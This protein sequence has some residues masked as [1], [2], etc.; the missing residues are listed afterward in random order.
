MLRFGRS[1]LFVFL[2]LSW[3]KEVNSGFISSCVYKTNHTDIAKVLGE[4]QD[5]PEDCIYYYLVDREQKRTGDGY[6]LLLQPPPTEDRINVTVD[7]VLIR[8]VDLSWHD[9]RLSWDES[10]FSDIQIFNLHDAHH[11]WTPQ[12]GDETA[13]TMQSG[14]MSKINDVEISSS[15][16][17]SARVTFRYPTFCTINYYRYPE[18]TNDCCLFLSNSEDNHDIKYNIHTRAK[19][20]VEK[21]VAVSKVEQEPG[22]TVVTTVDSSV[23]TVEDRTIDVAKIAGVRSEFLRLCVHAVKRMSTLRMALRV[24]VTIA[25]M[26]ML[27]APLF[28]DL[29]TQ[30]Y[31]KLVTL[32][33]Q[34]MCFLFLCSIAP[35]NGFGG[36]KPKIYTFYE[37]LFVLSLISVMVTLMALALSRVRR[38]VPPMHGL[39]LTAKL[40]NKFLCCIEP[41]DSIAYERQFD[42]LPEARAANP[43]PE[44]DYTMEWRH[45]YI[46]GNNL[47]SGISFTMFVLL[48]VFDIV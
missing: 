37:F 46:A 21:Q 42:E 14:C 35:E 17:V 48:T 32:C 5:L 19:Q 15:G 27:V 16:T 22:V 47:F 3:Y 29:K 20:S 33:L 11:I 44:R 26:L 45:I 1:E 2:L 31:V 39:Y 13:C 10:E 12:F 38:T 36:I 30:S 25:T 28:G 24:P 4:K 6:H 7:D 18:E 8:T 9:D 43:H 34:T 41:D 23:W 40:L